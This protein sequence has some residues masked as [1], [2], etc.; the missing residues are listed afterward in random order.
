MS[1]PLKNFSFKVRRLDFANADFQFGFTSVQGLGRK[2]DVIKYRTGSDGRYSRK[3]PGLVEYDPITME[4]GIFVANFDLWGM[5]E[6]V[7]SYQSDPTARMTGTQAESAIKEDIAIILTQAKAGG[8]LEAVRAWAVR[9]SW[10]SSFSVSNF[11]ANTSD[12]AKMTLVVECDYWEE[13]DATSLEAIVTK[14]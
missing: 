10:V 4:Q 1:D 13:V 14:L 2:V 5:A 6:R 9:D 8:G 7:Y 3:L 12:V 11:D